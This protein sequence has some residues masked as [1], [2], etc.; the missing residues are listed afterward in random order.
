MSSEIEKTTYPFSNTKKKT[1]KLWKKKFF[2]VL[3]TINKL[4]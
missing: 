1:F 3:K 4:G 2:L